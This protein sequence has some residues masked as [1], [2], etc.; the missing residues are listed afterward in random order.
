[1]YLV[2]ET[3]KAAANVIF[4]SSN[5]GL[6]SKFENFF[7]WESIIR[8]PQNILEFSRHKYYTEKDFWPTLKII[9][10]N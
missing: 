10:K 9:C 5:L 2:L 7:L 1:M 3:K 8:N 6:Y 4:F